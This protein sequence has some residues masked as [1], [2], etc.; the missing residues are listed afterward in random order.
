[1][2][3]GTKNEPVNRIISMMCEACSAHVS[4]YIEGVVLFWNVKSEEVRR[5]S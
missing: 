3:E 2:S 5:V 1:M 4:L